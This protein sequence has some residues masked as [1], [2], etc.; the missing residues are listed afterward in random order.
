MLRAH[1]LDH[2]NAWL[3]R[4]IHRDTS[5][6]N[7]WFWVPIADQDHAVHNWCIDKGMP[8][9]CREIV[10][11]DWFC[12]RPKMIGDFS[13]VLDFLEDSEKALKEKKKWATT[14]SLSF[15]LSAHMKV[16][17]FPLQQCRPRA[18]PHYLS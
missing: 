2:L 7:T 10:K 1:N 11:S 4:L 5:D 9:F 8:K 15:C 13:L 12:M 3:C 16:G 14:V 17:N 6:G 18:S